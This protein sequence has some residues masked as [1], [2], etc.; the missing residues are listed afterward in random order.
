MSKKKQQAIKNYKKQKR[1]V[2]APIVALGVSSLF[3]LGAQAVNVSAQTPTTNAAAVTSTM[4]QQPAAANANAATPVSAQQNLTSNIKDTI[5]VPQNYL[6]NA[7]SPGPFTAG[8]NQVIPFEAFGGDGM[9]TRLLLNSSDGAPWS[10]NGANKNAALLPVDGLQ[11]GQY[12]YEVDLS[13]AA[14]GKQDAALL[15]DLQSGQAT[16]YTATVKVYAAKDGKADTSQAVAQKNVTINFASDIQKAVSANIKDSITVPANYLK[17]AV[18]PGPFT[19]G[20]N[21]VIP[22]E[23]FGGDGM[24]TRLLLNSSDGAPWSDNGSKKNAALLPV[25]GLKNG[26]YFYE[27]DLSGTAAGKQDAALLSDLQSGKAADYTATVKVYAA[28]DGKADTSKTVAEKNVK[29][30]LASNVQKNVTDNIKDSI[31]VPQ[32]YL[33]NAV[34]PGPFT[35]GVNQVIPFEAFGGDGMLTRLLLKSSDGAPWSDNGSKKNA[36]LL[37]VEGL[38]NG[39]YF[40][41]VDLDGNAAGKQDAALLDGLKASTATKYNATVKVYAAKDGQADKSQV[42]GQKAV[43]INLASTVQKNVTDNIKDSITVPASYLKNA[44]SPGPFTA[45]VNQ[46]IPFEAFGGDG[47]LTRLLLKSSDGAPWSDNGSK[48]NAALLPIEGLQKGQYFYEVD[49]AGSASGK[50]DAALLKELQEGKADSYKATVKVYVAKDGQADAAQVVG[51]KNVTINLKHEAAKPVADK[52]VV[53]YRAYNPNSG[54]HLYTASKT[55][56]AKAV[57]AGW[58]DEGQAWKAATSGT[59]VYR[60]YNPNSGEHFYTMDTK[61]YNKV[62]AAG[63]HKE[64]FAFYSNADKGTPIYRAFNP[65]AKGAGSH[66]FTPT[67]SE[68]NHLGKVGWHKEG[69]AFYGVK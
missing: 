2:S 22:F 21:Q 27:V 34:S 16:S 61:E 1:K 46:K 13:G 9:L 54:E 15:S 30:N 14:A 32:N 12:F 69:I 49:L 35:A 31:T 10:D 24:L 20:V 45:G 65:N 50:S 66:F 37:P 44:V 55:E 23:A 29:I 8:V 33:I 17:N 5:T 4:N 62:A 11:N 18:S 26:Q 28:K 42:V 39:Q 67:A 53:L 43:S 38:Q 68:W 58:H 52:G 48:K 41:E 63:W 19:A 47:M 64:G 40:Y 36:A 51:Q 56:F 59:P 57:K 25:E 60:L 7:K 3:A 6:D